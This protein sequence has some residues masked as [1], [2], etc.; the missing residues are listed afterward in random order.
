MTVWIVYSEDD[1]GIEDF[2]CHGVYASKEVAEEVAK[3][4][5]GWIMEAELFA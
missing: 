3:K 2:D 4:F 5:R 1:F